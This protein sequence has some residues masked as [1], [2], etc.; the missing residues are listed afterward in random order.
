M[1]IR[2]GEI[3]NKHFKES[4]MTQIAFAKKI[5]V[6]RQNLK[7]VVFD[8]LSIDTDLLVRISKVLGHN[9]FQYYL[10]E[11]DLPQESNYS[12]FEEPKPDYSVSKKH[13]VTVSFDI[14]DPDIKLKLLELIG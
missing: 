4:G 2:I 1:N 8:K 12:K 5:N 3:I 6:Q 10:N 7:A 11:I 14:T 13:R 9:F